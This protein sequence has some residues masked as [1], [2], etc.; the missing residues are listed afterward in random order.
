MEEFATTSKPSEPV[1]AS[2][3]SATVRKFAKKKEE[4]FE[5]EESEQDNDDDFID[6]DKELEKVKPAKRASKAKSA[7]DSKK[8]KSE[9]VESVGTDAEGT[10][11]KKFKYQFM[12][13]EM[14]VYYN[15]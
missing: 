3:P 10:P 7:T 5:V 6:D 12:I 15:F 11:K 2:K 1:A 4:V 8:P 9:S 13:I 14:S